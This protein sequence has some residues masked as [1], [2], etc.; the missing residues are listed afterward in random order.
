MDIKT[1]DTH[2][3]DGIEI[4]E[5]N[6]EGYNRTMHFGEWRV[7]FL[8]WAE[9]FEE[10]SGFPPE[11]HFLTDEVF[12]LLSGSAFLEIGDALERVELKPCRIYNVHAGVWHRVSVSRDA[13]LLIVE[14]HSTGPENSEYMY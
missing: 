12:V 11:R 1:P 2:T 10:G 9:K 3:P 14:N 8:N 6:G 4:L 13:K 5:Y 7:P